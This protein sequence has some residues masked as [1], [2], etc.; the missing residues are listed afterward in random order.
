MN[1]VRR[2]A[3]ESQLPLASPLP[4]FHMLIL[5]FMPLTTDAIWPAPQHTVLMHMHKA[6]LF[7]HLQAS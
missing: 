6:I 7:F 1:G 4:V 3:I 2:G 5:G